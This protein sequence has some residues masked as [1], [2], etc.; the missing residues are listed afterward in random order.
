[1]GKPRPVHPVIRP[2]LYAAVQLSLFTGYDLT[3]DDIKQFRQLNSK[4][5]GHPEYG[6]RP[7]SM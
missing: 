6:L 3:L 7:A 2:R 4:T 5:A 1:M